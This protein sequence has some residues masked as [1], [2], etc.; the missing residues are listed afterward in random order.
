MTTGTGT[1]AASTSLR[2]HHM[3]LRVNGEDHEVAFAPNK[4]LLEVLREDMDLTGTKHGCE[5]GE[6]GACT[7]LIDREPRLSCLT[8]ALECEDV[9][10]DT[11][12]GLAGPEGP[13]PLQQAHAEGGASQCGYC[14]SGFL[15][16]AS[17]V[18]EQNPDVDR[19]T[20]REELSGNLCRCTGYLQIFNAIET[21]AARMRAEGVADVE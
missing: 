17:S 7:V 12:E 21:A 6:C 4:T 1:S 18:L 9:A 5:L 14:T 2:K 13:G 15:M 16:T 19:E 8:L 11:I 20:L 3:V 10:I